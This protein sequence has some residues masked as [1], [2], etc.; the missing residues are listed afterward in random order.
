LRVILRR[1]EAW[2][3]SAME[4]EGAAASGDASRCVVGG[5]GAGH[6]LQHV[7]SFVGAP[8]VAANIPVSHFWA[9]AAASDDVW[10]G[11]CSE[12]WADKVYVP[13]RFRDRASLPRIRAFFC[14]GRGCSEDL[15]HD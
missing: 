1:F 8:G 13:A 6:L 14:L 2:T 11:F 9:S 10:Q 4:L 5:L 3:S 12:L 15:D 7:L